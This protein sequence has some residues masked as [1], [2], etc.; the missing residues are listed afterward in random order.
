MNKITLTQEDIN[1]LPTIAVLEKYHIDINELASFVLANSPIF[2]GDLMEY[3][4]YLIK[5]DFISK[6]VLIEIANSQKYNQWLKGVSNEEI[7]SSI[8]CLS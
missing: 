4:K 6:S 1:I 5:E 2:N 7:Q 3:T 8:H